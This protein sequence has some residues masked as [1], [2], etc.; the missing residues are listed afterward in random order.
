M[1][2]D[3][4]GFG[5]RVTIRASVMFPAGITI[6]QFA[7]DADPLDSPSQQLADVGMGLNGDMVHWRTAQPIPVTLNVLPNTGDDRNLR[8]LADANRV[9]KGKNPTNDD[10][11]MTIYYP[12]GETRMLTG[13]VITDGMVGNSVASA[14]RLKTKPYVFKFENQVT[15]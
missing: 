9:A 3:I 12:S 8:I 1:S 11:T 15:A 13:G 5:L 6:T 2:N 4:S 7:D 14:G 10:I